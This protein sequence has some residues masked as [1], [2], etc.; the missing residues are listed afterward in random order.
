MKS[1]REAKLK[2]K[3]KVKCWIASEYRLQEDK[4]NDDKRKME[5]E[6]IEV[7]DLLY[8]RDL[9]YIGTKHGKSDNEITKTSKRIMMGT[10]ALK[11]LDTILKDEDISIFTKEL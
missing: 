5:N 7:V 4:S 6:T 11:R 3:G 2:L 10:D 8:F 9:L 1:Q